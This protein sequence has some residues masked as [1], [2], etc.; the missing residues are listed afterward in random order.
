MPP[1]NS[2][3]SKKDNINDGGDR[4]DH[5]HLFSKLSGHFFLFKNK[6]NSA[7]QN[8]CLSSFPSPFLREY[9]TECNLFLGVL[10]PSAVSVC[11]YVALINNLAQSGLC[12]SSAVARKNY[13]SG[14]VQCEPRNMDD[15]T[16]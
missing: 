14:D 7:S 6:I 5:T 15:G 12:S 1:P 2:L 10:C 16:T 13:R 11:S 8:I 4:D 9:N 3:S